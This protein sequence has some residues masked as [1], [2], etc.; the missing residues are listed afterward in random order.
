MA[1]ITTAGIDLAKKNNDTATTATVDDES[2][3]P[4]TGLLGPPGYYA[5]ATGGLS[6]SSA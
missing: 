3:R 2:V 6:A 1:Q 5:D 4:A